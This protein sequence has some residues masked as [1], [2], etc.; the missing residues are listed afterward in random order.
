MPG[1][2]QRQ[3]D[4]VLA[5]ESGGRRNARERQQEDQHEDCVDRDACA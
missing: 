2:D 3:E 4:V 1:L 5:E